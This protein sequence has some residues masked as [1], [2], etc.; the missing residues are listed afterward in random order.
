MSDRSYHTAQKN[1]PNC[2]FTTE[3]KNFL[4]GPITPGPSSYITQ[5]A[6]PQIG[7]KA[8]VKVPFTTAERFPGER[9]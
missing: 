1:S 7:D 8:S 5:M 9:V 2:R 3:K 4:P 6:T